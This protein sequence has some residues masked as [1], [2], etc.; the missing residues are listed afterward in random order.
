MELM[1]E[2]VVIKKG[3]K[4]AVGMEKA[5]GGGS[6]SR[7]EEAEGRKE[8]GEVESKSPN[9]WRRSQNFDLCDAQP[10]LLFATLVQRKVAIGSCKVQIVRLSAIKRRCRA[11]S[12]QTASTQGS[13]L[14]QVPFNASKARPTTTFLEHN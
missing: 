7:E 8:G 14:I 6:K 5:G 10:S 2:I 3:V 11:K 4:I 9:T 12:P 13:A 1:E